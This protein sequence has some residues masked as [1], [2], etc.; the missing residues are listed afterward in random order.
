MVLFSHAEPKTKYW[1]QNQVNSMPPEYVD[2]DL[3]SEAGRLPHVLI[4]SNTIQ[5]MANCVWW[6]L[7]VLFVV[8]PHLL[9]SPQPI[10]DAEFV[11]HFDTSGNVTRRVAPGFRPG[12]DINAMSV[13]TFKGEVGKRKY[14]IERDR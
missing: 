10:L 12:S 14:R 3:F 4:S 2:S 8:P 7:P 13:K 11:Y 6:T 9:I 5:V 1:N